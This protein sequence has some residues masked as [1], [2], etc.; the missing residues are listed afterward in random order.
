MRAQSIEAL[1]RT[2]VFTSVN[3]VSNSSSSGFHLLGAMPSSELMR[4][5]L[6][7]GPLG[8]NFSKI[9]SQINN[10]RSRKC[11]W[12]C[13]LQDVAQFIRAS[14]CYKIKSAVRLLSQAQFLQNRTEA[15]SI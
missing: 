7:I 1:W 10:F 12:R 3:W 11:I 2:Y 14:M 15:M 6:S 4:T 8:S 13:R 9:E 5:L